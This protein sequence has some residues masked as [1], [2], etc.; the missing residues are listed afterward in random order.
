MKKSS[1][2]LILLLAFAVQGFGQLSDLHY[3][4]PL[5]QISNNQA[6]RQQAF[7]L[8][9]PE[10]TPFDVEVYR[11]SGAA[12]LA[13]LTISN[14]S[15]VQY[16]V[17]DGDNN[18][19][20]VTNTN[21]GIVLNNSGL[22]FQSPGGEKFYVN[23]RGRS[24]AQATSLTSKG[25]QA[26]GTLFKWGGIPNR[27]NNANLTSTLG[28]M[29]TENGTTV[30]IFGYDPGC[31]FRLQGD[32]DGITADTQIIN[33]NAGESFV[34]E[35]RKAE[36]T[37]NI[38][39][40][41]GATIQSDKKIAIS[42]GGLNVG[43][44]TTSGSRDA[45][46]DQPV[47]ENVL[48]REYVFVRGNGTDE[49][50]FPIIIATRNNTE[51][52][53]NGST[54]PSATLNTGE[55]F[56]IPGTNYSGG[57]AGAN[58]YVTTSKETYAYQSL[59][60]STGI[61]T[62]GLNFIAPVNC[63]L[64]P[65]LDN[66][67]DIRDVDGLNFN[68]GITIIAS[69][70]TPDTN[71]VVTDDTGI[72]AIP[73]S[74]PVVGTTEW[75]SFYVPG[76]TGNVKVNS[77][78]PIAVGFLGVNSNAGIAGYFSG[79]DSVP[80]VELDITGGG[81]L[82]GADVIEI[83]ADFDAYQW[84]QNGVLIPGANSNAYTPTAPG[85]FF[86]RVTRGS[87]TY[88]SAV[89]SAYNCDPEIVL[90]KTV[91]TSPALEGDIVT[92]T[93]EV[94]HLGIDPVTDLV[95]NEALPS[96]LTL[97]SATPSFGTWSDPDWTIGNMLSGEVHTLTVVA[98]VNDVPA[99]ITVTNTVSNTQNEV[100]ANALPDDPTED[101]VIVNSEI[102]LTKQDSA[103]LDGS[104]DTVGELI[105]Y[106][107]V[108]ANTGSSVLSN[109]T[110]TDSN[111]DTG[112]LS[113]ATVTTL[114]VGASANFTATHTITQ[115]DIEAGQ[116]VNTAT[117]QADLANGSTIT[118]A[119]DDPDDPTTAA[120]DPTITPIEQLGGLVLEKIAQP[121]PDGL[122][123][124]LG[125]VIVY[126]LTVTN[127]GNVSLN[128]IV[129]TDPNADT[130]SISPS[131]VANLPVGT[132]VVFTAEHTIVQADFDNGTV[133]NKAQ[134]SGTEPTEGTTITDTSDD[135]T[136]P[137]PE[138]S[139]VVG[140][141]QEGQLSV[142]KVAAPP[143][144]GAYDTVGEVISYT[145]V[146]TS[147]GNVTLTDINVVDPN[148]DTITLDSTTG[149]DDGLDNIVDSMEPNE[150]ATFIA[151]H[152]LTQEDLD[153]VQV[154][155]VATVGSQDTVGGSVTDL[156]DD[157]NDPTSTTEDP[158]VVSLFELPGMELSKASDL[159]DGGDGLQAGDTIDYTF[160]LTNTGNVSLS[161][162]V[163]NDPQLG[164]DLTG[165]AGGDSDG[166]GELDVT[167]TWTYNASYTLD[168]DDIDAGSITNT[169]TT[170]ADS[171]GGTGA[172]D[173]SDDPDDPTTTTDDPTVTQLPESPAMELSKA[174]DLDDG[175]DG[176][177]AGDTIDYTF[178]LTNTGNVSLS[179]VVVND[180]Q[181]G[182]D[183]TGP[184]G[185]DSDGDGELDVTETWTYT[186]SYTLDQDDI[187]AGSITNTATTVADSPGGTGAGDTSDDPDD[188]TT[189][190]DD[191]TVT[192]LPESPA[193]ELS[194]ASVLDDGGDGLGTGD[195]IDYTFTL[196]NTGNVSLSNVVVNDPQLGGDLTG[197]AGGDSDGDGEL[198]VTET[199]TYNAS[200]TLD[201]DDIDA[202]SIT[203]TATTVADSPGGTGAGDTSDDPDDPT[204]TTDDPTVT[205]LPESPA[206]EL[207]KASALDD[208]GDG[209]GTGDTIDYTFTLT[210][211]GNVSLSNVVVNDPQLGG[212]LTGP[213]GGDSDGDGELDVTETWTYNASYTLDQDD[214]DAGSITNTA[215]TVAD[216]PGGTGAGDTSDDPDDPTTTTDDPTVTQ[217]PESPAMELSKASDL[218]DGGDGLQAGDTID[219]TFTLTNTGN[220]S[221]SNVVVNDPQLG[222]DLTGPAGGD[223]DGD[224][225]LDVTETWT[226]NASY[227]L[228]Q[229][230]IDAGSITNTA[231]TVA[232]SPGGTGAGDTSD[233]PDD[234]TTTTDDP[235]V[236]TLAQSPE[237]LLTK[238]AQP[239]TDGAF[240]TLGEVVTYTLTVANTG[241]V[242]ISDV[243]LVDVNADSGSISPASIASLA[244]G[245]TTTFTATHTIDQADL[246]AGLVSNQA[247]VNGNNP[248]NMPVTDDSDD[249]S[250][251]GANDP[252]IIDVDQMPE[253]TTTKSALPA[254]DGAYD[255]AG[256]VLLYEIVVV[257]TGNVT[258][259]D[260]RITDP[261]ADAGSISPVL[262]TSLAPGE[263]VLFS[264]GHS[265]TQA[266]LDFGSVSNQAMAEGEDPSGNPV[267]DDSDDP[268]TTDPD[269]STVTGIPQFASLTIEKSTTNSFY[270][271]LGDLIVY[272]IVVTN[273]GNISLNGITVTDANAQITSASTIPV[274]VPGDSVTLTAEHVVV[275]ADIDVG[276]VANTA[277]A[278][279]TAP[280]GSVIIAED[281]DDPDDLT[282]ID[283]DGDGDFEDPTLSFFD[284]DGDGIPD[285]NDPDDD[286]DGLTDEEE[287]TLGTDPLNPDTDG[288]GILDGQET[289]DDTN[290]LDGCDS[291]GG[292]P[293]NGL[294]C[295]IEIESD[296]VNPNSNEGIFQINFIEL[297][298][299]NTVKIYNRWGVLVFNTNGYDNN[300]NAFKGIS[301][302][303]A[304]IQKNAEL[305]VGVYFYTIEYVNNGEA[306]TKS[307]Y[308]YI[309]R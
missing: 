99:D 42:N 108:V 150:T 78:G 56:E 64:P 109:I 161:N 285:T 57:S 146:A 211:T 243:T 25:R 252:T 13:T 92:F 303:R 270:T 278:T 282:N 180:P 21:T 55:Y 242:T 104:Y 89:I 233:D 199:W 88:D 3:L 124:A 53:V 290:P 38:D 188:P 215:T 117:A 219:Y 116:V 6:I 256:E 34:L 207:S 195:T 51:V 288:D 44:R 264:A 169:A 245:V 239:S 172:G 9:T 68:G 218:D 251:I 59:A 192:Q 212:D 39:G 206:M 306:K 293:P 7:Y 96:Q 181:L 87:C 157:P 193:M 40:W 262:V 113:P 60:G 23:F 202:G 297:F 301:N 101:L 260:V 162:V 45:A 52:F 226:Y 196:T 274:L 86:V 148:A 139:T 254:M 81:C 2:L 268:T 258:L 152:S 209:L 131:S 292:T 112:S 133:T 129:I 75:K 265:I 223:S 257:N 121:A 156:S 291:K 84:F 47:P 147:V 299:N 217:L 194:K 97:V 74:N 214:I 61:Q 143:A 79:F 175:G 17:A 167:E 11:G 272:E 35:A 142:T 166:D 77:T 127:T 115:A 296:L 276:S 203:N 20:L 85:D 37:A 227:T 186:A 110:I 132:S 82:P 177:Q 289:V 49:T 174:S 103:P 62:I 281:S 118:D 69:T 107:F 230:D 246:D 141:P 170:V 134:V 137:A 173:T 159:D 138:D 253:L 33:L 228:D 305:P 304:T 238:I 145:I 123:D 4:P 244:P 222:G 176:L 90:T 269:D 27:A 200:Y 83:S 5:K 43:V 15:P 208:G 106:N 277:I 105:T 12:P 241:N 216:S 125:E 221:L 189:T 249:P 140:I 164:G 295:D 294:S 31:E 114:A 58:M 73:A 18:I 263:T 266:D 267:M 182:G 255:T 308:L 48:G 16:N 46:I 191:P 210:N 185:G 279:V 178:T 153:A 155:N 24:S 122:Y 248:M 205:Q 247:T 22:R 302:G 130:G 98:R 100:E 66:L 80:I 237:L 28:I 14:A 273:T 286:N 163:V 126:E 261:N 50:E 91:N 307:G 10:T 30:T 271:N 32:P 120:D 235:T 283:I 298:P 128:N 250:T 29:A 154:T 65:D 225:E 76:L 94:E 158:T 184:A 204:T 19:T 236:T 300:T 275:Q 168:Q 144:D 190:T 229:D 70:L 232:D 284:N 197:P 151:T 198:D 234:P 231:T 135:P 54:T 220:V 171:P 149:T 72:V 165:P 119:S 71:I 201:Q 26:L 179:N 8:S 224:G 287:A 36:T 1:L 111:I 187:D 280:N 136:T 67:A 95:I 160:T 213:A 93:V 102:N 240:D 309:N 259:T 63:L 183:L 41:L